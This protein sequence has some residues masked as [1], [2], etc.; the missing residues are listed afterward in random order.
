MTS[1]D[2]SDVT[3]ANNIF[4]IGNDYVDFSSVQSNVNTFLTNS[5][6]ELLTASQ[7]S[8]NM[9]R[10]IK[11]Q[12][13]KLR[14]VNDNIYFTKA[15]PATNE[16]KS[17]LKKLHEQKV[18][19]EDSIQSLL[20][21]QT[22]YDDEL[23][24]RYFSLRSELLNLPLDNRTVIEYTMEDG[25]RKAFTVSPKVV[26][27]VMNKIQNGLY[28]LEETTTYGS[29][30]IDDFD[31]T[32]IKNIAVIDV[33]YK[34]NVKN[35]NEGSFFMYYNTASL[36]NLQRY[37]IYTESDEI[38]TENCLVYALNQNG[39]NTDNIKHHLSAD[40]PRTKLTEIAKVLGIT[41]TLHYFDKTYKIKTYKYNKNQPINA[42]IAIYENHYFIH[43]PVNY[44]LWTIKNYQ[45]FLKTKDTT[46][47]R[48]MSNGYYDR[49]SS[50]K[51]NSLTFIREMFLNDHFKPLNQL[52]VQNILAYV[53]NVKNI[54]L[55]QNQ[56]ESCT[57][58]PKFEKE[59]FTKHDLLLNN[60]DIIEYV[61]QDFINQ[62]KDNDYDIVFADFEAT[63][64]K[65]IHEPYLIAYNS[66]KDPR[67]TTITGSNCAEKFIKIMK[68]NKRIY[69]H[70]LK[71]DWQFL[72]KSI[73][74]RSSIEQGSKIYSITGANNLKFVDSYKMI[75]FKL[76]DFASVFGLDVSK[77]LCP[78]DL[79]TSESVLKP[80]IRIEKVKEYFENENT[81][82]QFI[83]Q[84]TDRIK[85]DKFHHLHYA[86]DYCKMDVNVLY[87]GLMIFNYWVRSQIEINTFKFLT[88]SS[89]A[90]E[91]AI[92]QGCF[93]DVS[94]L[95]G[96]LRKFTER[97]AWGGRVCLRNNEPTHVI[98]D[99]Q[100][101]DGVS[102]YP[103]AMARIKGFP[104]GLPEVFTA[105]D[106][107]T[108]N[109][110]K[111]DYYIVKIK[112][113]QV[114]E[115]L[116]IPVFRID[117][118]DKVLWPSEKDN[119]YH[120]IV[121]DKITLEDM[122]NFQGVEYEVIEGVYWNN[123]FNNKINDT[124]KHVFDIRTKYKKEGNKVQ[125]L[126]K[127]IMNSIYGKTMTK[128][129]KTSTKYIYGH[130]EAMKFLNKNFNMIK[131]YLTA[132]DEIYIMTMKEN[133]LKHRNMV[134]CGAY[135]LSMSKRIMNEVIHTAK[136]INCPVFYT[137]TDSLHLPDKKVDELELKYQEIYNRQLQGSNLGQFHCD[138]SLPA[139]Q[140]I[141]A[142]ESIFISP[143][144]Y[145]DRVVGDPIQVITKYNEATD[146]FDQYRKYMNGNEVK[147]T[148]NIIT[149]T[150]EE[151][152]VM[153]EKANLDDKG[154]VFK[155]HF[156]LKGVSEKSITYLAKEYY[157]DNIIDLYKSGQ[158]VI[159]DL[160][161]DKQVKFDFLK[162]GG[163]SSKQKF[164]RKI[165]F[166]PVVTIHL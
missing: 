22:T 159:F 19:L 54:T 120:E 9:E 71:Y 5:I 133:Y 76:E 26:D 35:Q 94:Q 131:R 123:G 110:F 132:D 60:K 14:E 67:I 156:R 23:D 57:I 166:K 62:N 124:I 3:N 73:K 119:I 91:F 42:E 6:S 103:S 162:T 30:V 25:T 66:I 39:I 52:K 75:S 95:E 45:E 164:L 59:P 16:N 37:Q 145:C 127:L 122:I 97:A 104:K 17:A 69:F 113:L 129:S 141:K 41:I 44:H 68:Q 136:L 51:T 138:F 13:Q 139:A 88:S 18:K 134:H 99:M 56:T 78:Y 118:E 161:C 34:S 87:Q 98:G 64:D 105:Q 130:E 147:A 70:N 153:V 135:T 29:D 101:F 142:T 27:D 32:K 46:I 4:R 31:L 93:E 112:I 21:V 53:N 84:A 89:I 137:D 11:S 20:P 155:Y 65:A 115:W 77:Q 43:E 160:L 148:K 158:D 107:K 24:K 55:I 80:Y 114:K 47:Y 7:N 149:M 108:E 33:P 48:K 8:Y 50:Y 146:T 157:H 28:H 109:I 61:R 36:L 83:D 121:V 15:Q 154:M 111:S 10:V 151:D 72:F 96:S 90:Q 128:E 125:E 63:T 38:N 85:D 86:S 102:L 79:Y 49:S 144:I 140:N 81:F 100:D 150:A 74:I 152:N 106:W 126:Y 58:K 117:L 165:Q 143:K 92:H 1:I 82:N 40:I 2:F 12:K 163:V 116:D